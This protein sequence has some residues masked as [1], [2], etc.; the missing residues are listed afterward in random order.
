MPFDWKTLVDVAERLVALATNQV[1]AVVPEAYLR[2]S[3]S[4][5]YIGAFGH[6]FAY[7]SNF[8]EYSAKENP[9]DH[10]RL[11]EHLRRKKRLGAAD[12]LGRL[13]TL[14]NEADYL[15]ELPWDDQA[16]TAQAAIRVAREVIA[17]LPP[18]Q[19]KK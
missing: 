17:F 8:L 7:A 19:P 3:V 13:R 1:D 12:R 6:A 11:R 4:R 5:A 15:D 14:R 16:T 2:S 9:E 10:G 18:P